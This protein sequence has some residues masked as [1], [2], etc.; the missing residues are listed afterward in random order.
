MSKKNFKAVLTK[1]IS[2]DKIENVQ[3]GIKLK[4]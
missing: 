1:L 3:N 2:Q 4:K